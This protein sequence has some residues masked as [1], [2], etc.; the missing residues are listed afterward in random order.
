MHTKTKLTLLTATAALLALP[1]CQGSGDSQGFTNAVQ[2]LCAPR[3]P[4]AD[5]NEDDALAHLADMDYIPIG[6]VGVWITNE[7]WD[8]VYGYSA[9][10]DG[11]IY[12]TKLCAM[13]APNYTE[14]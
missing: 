1:A 3:M 10:E 5:H 7:G 13:T 2:A 8:A 12:R 14:D 9:Y 6:S 4:D 11:V